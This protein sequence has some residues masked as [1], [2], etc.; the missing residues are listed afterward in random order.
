MLHFPKNKTIKIANQAQ[1]AS[2]IYVETM[3]S[4]IM[5]NSSF[6]NETAL[7]GGVFTIAVVCDIDIQN[8][9]IEVI[10]CL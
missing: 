6:F 10:F 7:T 5:H 8:V 2:S 4:L 3:S 1:K 9:Y